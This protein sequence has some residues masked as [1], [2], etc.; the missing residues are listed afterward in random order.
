MGSK[1][2]MA[3]LALKEAADGADQ[4][5]NS[6]DSNDNMDELLVCPKCGYHGKEREFLLNAKPG[7]DS[8]SQDDQ[9]NNNQDQS[10]EY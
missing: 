9:G 8:N 10:S 5:G 2:Q 6:M 4:Q 3:M 7:Q 1:N